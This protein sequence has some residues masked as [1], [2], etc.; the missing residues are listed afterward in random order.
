MIPLDPQTAVEQKVFPTAE[1][2]IL[3][4]LLSYLP[5]LMHFLTLSSYFSVLMYRR[6]SQKSLLAASCFSTHPSAFFWITDDSNKRGQALWS[7]DNGT[8]YPE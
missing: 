4:T 8:N 6:C 3:I 5:V 2:Y 7:Y 1:A